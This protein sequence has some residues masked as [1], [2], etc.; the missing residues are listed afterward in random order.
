MNEVL[1]ST[2][3][4]CALL[5]KFHVRC[6]SL[7]SCP[8]SRRAASQSV[9]LRASYLVAPLCPHYSRYAACALDAFLLLTR[10]SENAF[11][12]D[13]C[14]HGSRCADVEHTCRSRPRPTSEWLYLIRDG[15]GI[16]IKLNFCHV[17]IPDHMQ[18]PQRLLGFEDE[19]GP[20][21]RFPKTGDSD[22]EIVRVRE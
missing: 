8:P 22:W 19:S 4:L 17:G 1:H 3:G 13:A 2:F 6:V 18:G 14:L 10:V 12:L 20:E 16:R 15:F 11:P 5:Y 9:K 21:F 7:P